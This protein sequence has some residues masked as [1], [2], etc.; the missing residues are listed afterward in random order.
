MNSDMKSLFE[1]GVVDETGLNGRLTVSNNDIPV[2][3][4]YLSECLF[5]GSVSSGHYGI[6]VCPP[7]FAL[8]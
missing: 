2:L 6:L 1:G 7:A 4:A 8:I 3:H 5:E